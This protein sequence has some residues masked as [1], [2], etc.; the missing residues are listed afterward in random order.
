MGAKLAEI[1][2]IMERRARLLADAIK[3]RIEVLLYLLKEPGQRP[4]FTK[5]LSQ[6]EALAWWRAHRTDPLGMRLM[7]TMSPGQIMDIDR[8]LSAQIEEEKEV[9]MWANS[10]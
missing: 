1:E 2:Y 4:V 7:A 6:R 5:K 3:H 10:E 9:G 8:A